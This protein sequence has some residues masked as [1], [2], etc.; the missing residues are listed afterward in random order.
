MQSM[1]V[2]S[3]LHAF[4][5]AAALAAMLNGAALAQTR[6]LEELVSAVVRIKTHIHPDGRTV[7]NLG[8]ERQGSGIVIDENGLILTIG[9]L[10]V[11]AYAAEIVTNSGRTLAADVLGYDHESGFGLLRT[12][13]PTG[14]PPI[15]LGKSADV[16]ERGPALVVSFGGMP[17]V[18]PV[19]VVAKREFAGEWEYLLDEAIFTAPPHPAWSGAALISRTG[20][21]VGVGSLIVSR[22]SLT[23][24]AAPG[25]MFVPIDRLTPILAE[26]SAGGPVSAPAR[27]WLGLTTNEV[28][29]RLI[30]SRVAPGGPAELAGLRRGEIILGVNGEPVRGLA[31]FYRKVWAQ[32]SAGAVIRLDVLHQD[33]L[34][35]VEVRSANRLD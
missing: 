19:H 30:A 3:C 7:P 27:P 34:R 16:N 5:L 23:G 9:Y 22:T 6:S 8:R 33:G 15:P 28:Q 29:G 11:E 35:S 32:G 31:D 18:A 4:L 12:K 2:R 13:V 21:L 25:N 14:L 26:L 24:E 17:M 10:M 1:R 20:T